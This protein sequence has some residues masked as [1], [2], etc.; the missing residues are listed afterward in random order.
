[1]AD[2]RAARTLS[3]RRN[4]IRGDAFV[5]RLIVTAGIVT[6]RLLVAPAPCEQARAVE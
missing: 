6:R 4:Y 2:G 1:M 3:E 5:A